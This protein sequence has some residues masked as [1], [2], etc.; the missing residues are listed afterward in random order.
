METETKISE[1]EEK[2]LEVLAGIYG[3]DADC[4]YMKYIAKELGLEYRQVKR[5]VRSLAR[6]GLAE[7]VRGLF[8]DDGMVAGSGYRATEKGWNL[9]D[10]KQNEKV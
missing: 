2:C 6:K 4:M 7:Y 1:R 10:K 9:I 8:D 5:A 3:N